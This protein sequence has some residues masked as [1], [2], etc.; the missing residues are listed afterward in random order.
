MLLRPLGDGRTAVITQP[1]H[2]W[3]SGRLIRAWGCPPFA[4][5]APFDQVCFAAENHDI[6]WLR[7]ESAPTPDP[8]TGLPRNFTRM[9]LPTHLAIWREGIDHAGHYGRYPALLVSLHATTIYRRYFDLDAARPEDAGRVRSFLDEQQQVQDR[10]S[11]SLQNDPYC[12]ATA[13]AP[14]IE[15]NRLLIAAVDW[16]SL[17]MC[18]SPDRPASVENVPTADGDRTS[19]TLTPSKDGTIAVDPW[20]FTRDRLETTIECRILTGR[21]KDDTSLRQGLAN[22]PRQS[23]PIHLRPQARER[24]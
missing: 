6:G 14:Q 16:M 4:A 8:E 9:P 10:L 22:A 11:A 21:Y 20:P 17:A 7:W 2:A 15:V 24:A 5:P 23:L 13:S 3:L 12:A 1:A 19:L 18:Q